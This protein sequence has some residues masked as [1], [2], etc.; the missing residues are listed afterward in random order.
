MVNMDFSQAPW[1][2][3]MLDAVYTLL[4]AF[5]TMGVLFAVLRI[6]PRP[7]FIRGRW[8]YAKL[9]LGILATFLALTFSA[10]YTGLLVR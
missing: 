8:L 1:G 7:R 5:V 2:T 9:T 3:N 4:V 10:L 6:L